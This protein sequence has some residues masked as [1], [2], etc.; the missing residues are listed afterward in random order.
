MVI[1]QKGSLSS[2]RLYIK[3]GVA[4]LGLM[5][6]WSVLADARGGIPLISP[7]LAC[8]GVCWLVSGLGPTAELGG[9]WKPPNNPT[10]Q[11]VA[12]LVNP[13][14]QSPLFWCVLGFRYRVTQILRPD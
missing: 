3:I 13:A 7:T 9:L 6:F 2:P 1:A 14:T 4:P 12:P 11:G 8:L 10:T 5:G